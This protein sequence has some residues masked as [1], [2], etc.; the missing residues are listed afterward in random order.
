MRDDKTM[1]GG[2]EILT[3]LRIIC[4]K[5]HTEISGLI[6]GELLLILTTSFHNECGVDISRFKSRK[7]KE[8]SGFCPLY[9]YIIYIYVYT[10]KRYHADL[11][12]ML[13]RLA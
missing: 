7:L 12:I 6:F 10:R 8:D 2:G 13:F 9:I 11:V 3:S 4:S 5:S 1:T